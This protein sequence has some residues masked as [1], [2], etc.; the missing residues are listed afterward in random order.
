MN[1]LPHAPHGD[2]GDSAALMADAFRLAL[3]LFATVSVL[4]S[5]ASVTSRLHLLMA[6]YARRRR[7]V[8]CR[9]LS[10]IRLLNVLCVARL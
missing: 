5:W 8:R 7:R 1:H 4:E 9:P 3:L 2:C 6:P 10:G